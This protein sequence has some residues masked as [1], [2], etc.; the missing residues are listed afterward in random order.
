VISGKDSATIGR[1]LLDN[2]YCTAWFGTD[3]KTPTRDASQSGPFGRELPFGPVG[4]AE[5]T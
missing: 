4:W 2:G 3:D 5:R 1:I